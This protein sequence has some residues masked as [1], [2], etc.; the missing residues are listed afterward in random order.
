MTELRIYWE[1][2]GLG[3]FSYLLASVPFG[4][5]IARVRGIDITSV[6]SGNIGATN[7]TRTLGKEWGAITLIFDALK[8][9]IPAF[10][11]LKTL[12]IMEAA[13]VGMLA[14]AGHCWSIF[15]KFRGGKGVA[16]TIG[17]L[18]GINPFVGLTFIFFWLAAF[19]VTRISSLAALTA[20]SL[21][22]LYGT[23]ID[24]HTPVIIMSF[25]LPFLI[26]YT[27]RENLERIKNGTE[28]R[29]KEITGQAKTESPS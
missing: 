2:I 29:M 21:L 18:L 9:F 14:I 8:G 4:Y 12:G 26:F 28:G 3:A 17:V 15:L 1:L 24:R 5:L 27:H 7:V 10:I 23:F 6:G 19:A 13:V 20:V 16:T 25:V 22:P 11:A